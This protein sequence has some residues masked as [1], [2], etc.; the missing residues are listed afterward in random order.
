V[1]RL[2]NL[3]S[4][5]IVAENVEKATSV[6]RRLSGF[7]LYN[8]I[9]AGEGLWFDNCQAIHTI[10]MRAR[11]DLIFLAKDDR[12]LRIEYSVPPNR[13]AVICAGACAVVELGAVSPQQRDIRP[14]D[15]LALE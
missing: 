2:R 11:V 10:G 9:H 8:T 12:I 7:L 15:R 4:G 1:G 6:W 5:S 14:G 13:L 3:R